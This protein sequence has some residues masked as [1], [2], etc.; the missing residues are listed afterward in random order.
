MSI[1]VRNLVKHYTPGVP[2]VRGVSFTVETGEMVGLLGPSGSG[3]TTLLRMIAGLEP[4]TAGEIYIHGRLVDPL[5]PQRRGVGVVFQNYAL[6]PHM[7][8][9]E[10]IAFGLR[11]Q[12]MRRAEIR[13]RVAELLRLVRLSGFEDRYPSQLSGG[14]AQ[15]VALARALAPKP[16]VLLLDEPFAAID[17]KVRKELR[18]WVRRVHEEVGITSIFVTHDQDEAFEVADRV[19]V[20]HDGELLQF[21]TP[22]QIL[23]SP[24][25]PFVAT[26]VGDV[27]EIERQVVGGAVSLGPIRLSAHPFQDGARVRVVIRP[28]DVVVAPPDGPPVG[29]R[30]RIRRKIAKGPVHAVQVELQDGLVLRAFVPREAQWALHPGAPVSVWIKDYQTFPA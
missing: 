1:E 17:T 12:R 29:P 3:K 24:A 8:V 25:T 26:F 13:E 30:A 11:V 15:R 6:F 2:A 7:T 18:E 5:P 14:Q 27:N 20:F 22:Q 10:N 28:T 23:E 4:Q 21:G 9:F 19:M 16:S